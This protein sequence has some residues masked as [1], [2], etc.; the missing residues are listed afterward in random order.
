MKLLELQERLRAHVPEHPERLPPWISWAGELCIGQTLPVILAVHPT[1]PVGVRWWDV[2]NRRVVTVK[3]LQ[4]N[5][6]LD[7]GIVRNVAKTAF[8]NPSSNAWDE[9]WVAQG[10]LVLPPMKCCPI[11]DGQGFL[12]DS[13]VCHNCRGQGWLAGA[14]LGP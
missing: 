1:I 13:S 8:W 2:C 10:N 7:V 9:K 4:N 5:T 11:C 12:P 6:A 3:A 14:L